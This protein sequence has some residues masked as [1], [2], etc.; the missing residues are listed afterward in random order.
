MSDCIKFQT[1]LN[2]T[3]YQSTQTAI[4]ITERSTV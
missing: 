4:S 2:H 1:V 3:A